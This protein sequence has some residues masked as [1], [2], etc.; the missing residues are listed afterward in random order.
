MS[1]GQSQPARGPRGSLQS[2]QGRTNNDAA[3]TNDDDLAARLRSLSAQSALHAESGRPATGVSLDDIAAQLDALREDRLWGMQPSEPSATP[4]EVDGAAHAVPSSLNSGFAELRPANAASTDEILERQRLEQAL[5]RLRQVRV[6]A[7]APPVASTPVAQPSLDELDADHPA[8]EDTFRLAVR[9]GRVMERP[10][11]SSYAR[12]ARE[13]MASPPPAARPPAAPA[14]ENTVRPSAPE[15]RPAAKLSAADAAPRRGFPF[16]KEPSDDEDESGRSTS[17]VGFK[18]P[19]PIPGVPEPLPTRLAI[20]A[21]KQAELA[22]D[23]VESRDERRPSA[24]ARG[25]VPRRNDVPLG[26]PTRDEPASGS[27]LPFVLLLMYSLVATGVAALALWRISQGMPHQLES[28]PDVRPPMS[29]DSVAYLL[30][31]ESASLPGGHTLKLGE[32][33]R[34]GNVRVRALAVTQ[35]PLELVPRAGMTD[36]QV[37]PTI[38]NVCQLHLEFENVSAADVVM[39]MDFGLMFSRVADRS[40]PGWIRSNQFMGAVAARDQPQSQHLL[41]PLSADGEWTLAGM[42]NLPVL[43]PGERIEI[44]VPTESIDGEL[45]PGQLAWRVHFRKGTNAES[46]WGVTTLVDVLFTAQDVIADA[47]TTPQQS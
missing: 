24:P 43:K 11:P 7:P 37:S 20:A 23:E 22:A 19:P 18:S 1:D 4:A 6:D 32:S 12:T 31:P 42:Q 41:F 46:G 28:L 47:A 2:E 17:N 26:H 45:P 13:E 38:D 9:A 35:G 40:D 16:R 8:E 39:P 25:N 27:S 36:G 14:F 5:S 3:A 33:R 34:F 21:I 10:E 44:R 29:G 30:I 15:V